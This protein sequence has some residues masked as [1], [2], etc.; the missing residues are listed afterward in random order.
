MV[1]ASSFWLLNS[2]NT[3]LTQHRKA[4]A[5]G[6]SSKT[7]REFLERNHKDDMDREETIKLTVKSLLEV[8]QTGAKNIEIAIMAPGKLI[9]M[10]PVEDIEGYVKNIEAEKQEEA[11]KKKTGRTPGTANAAILTRGSDESSDK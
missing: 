5:I 10:L 9:E 8:V 11:A 7:V 2:F 3:L 1:Y 6:R 4:N